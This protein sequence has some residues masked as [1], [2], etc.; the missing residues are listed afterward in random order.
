MLESLQQGNFAMTQQQQQQAQQSAEMQ[1]KLQEMMRRQRELME[2]TYRDAQGQRGQQGQQ[3]Q[4]GQK[5]QQQGGAGEQ[6]A[7]RRMLGDLMQQ[8]GEM[9]GQIPDGFG[10]AERSMKDAG[11]ALGNGQPGQALGPQANALE[12]LQQG[13]GQMMQ[14]LQQMM[15]MGQ[16]P[17]QGQPGGQP[18]QY[19]QGQPGGPM[20]PRPG[21]PRNFDPLGRSLPSSGNAND[22]NGVRIPE[23]SDIMRS[24]EIL[25]ELR[26]RAGEAERPRIEHD[27][28]DRLLRRF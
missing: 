15:G 2:Q 10:Q 5:G 19:S 23:A 13:A 28:I 27:Y 24:R 22:D 17:G 1:K 8:L 9:G 7:L 25:E 18:G 21:D 14:Q 20:Q 26:K 6:E 12:Q 4:Q 3:G 11:Q 16:G